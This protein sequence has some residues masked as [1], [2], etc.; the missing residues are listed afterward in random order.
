MQR[1][2]RAD[3]VAIVE[4][5]QQRFAQSEAVLLTDYRGLNVDEM[6]N[7]RTAL[8]DV[9]AQ[10]KIYKNTLVKL[11]AP[12]DAPEGLVDL[13][14]GPVAL[15]FTGKD[16]VPAA[17][18][19]RDFARN[20]EALVIKGALVSGRLLSAQEV[21]TLAT[22]PARDVVLAEIV[23]GFA[24]PLQQLAQMMNALL[25]EMAGLLSALAEQTPAEPVVEAEP[26]AEPEADEPEAVEP[27][28]PVVE[29]EADEPEAVAQAEPVAEPEPEP[30]PETDNPTE[31]E[32]EDQ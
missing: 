5:V 24:A 29:P 1:P 14:A 3:K 15:T 11:A 26:V 7:V 30:S 20:H 10:M 32:G 6:A 4:E 9:D 12:T 28:E 17:K 2:P 22:L 18:A 19:L 21:A 27:A 25:G 13:L 16:P 23:G 31:K 8:L